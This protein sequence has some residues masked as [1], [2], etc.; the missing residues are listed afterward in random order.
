MIIIILWGE[1]D[2]IIFKIYAHNN[3]QICLYWKQKGPGATGLLLHIQN[4]ST[5][6]KGHNIG[7][8]FFFFYN[9]GIATGAETGTR[10]QQLLAAAQFGA[11]TDQ[12]R[13]VLPD[14]AVFM[15][16][17]GLRISILYLFIYV[18]DRCRGWRV[19][20]QHPLLLRLGKM[21]LRRG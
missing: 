6:G 11:D 17:S 18:S 3:I 12:L 7:N 1:G 2:M 15:F 14:N 13:H 16:T 21:E 4:A 20:M 19:P 5:S 8:C 9:G 10:L